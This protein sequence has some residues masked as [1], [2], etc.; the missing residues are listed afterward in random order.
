[1]PEVRM[2]LS[3]RTHEA[4]MRRR[5]MMCDEL[6]ATLESLYRSARALTMSGLGTGQHEINSCIQRAPASA[7][8]ICSMIRDFADAVNR[9]T[10][11]VEFDSEI[12]AAPDVALDS[13]IAPVVRKA[14]FQ[15]I[16]EHTR[17]KS[18]NDVQWIGLSADPNRRIE[19][20]WSVAIECVQKNMQRA[21][22]AMRP[23]LLLARRITDEAMEFLDP[24][25]G[26][27][28][29]E[30]AAAYSVTKKLRAQ[31]DHIRMVV[32]QKCDAL[33]GEMRS[34]QNAIIRAQSQTMSLVK[35]LESI[36]P[37]KN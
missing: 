21:Y 30:R 16:D 13:P 22:P 32:N 35:N 8:T 26:P 14:F 31:I 11:L 17:L 10:E 7:H 36:G 6:C 25:A 20:R 1:M 3:L 27:I 9:L 28:A 12:G 19:F 34:V 15:A 5:L 18:W 29:E 37:S 2:L 4:R 23:V 33:E 24:L